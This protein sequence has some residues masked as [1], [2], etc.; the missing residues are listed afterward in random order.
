[1][2]VNPHAAESWDFETG[3]LPDSSPGENVAPIC[4]KNENRFF[5]RGSC[6]G[7]TAGGADDKIH[8]RPSNRAAVTTIY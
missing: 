4:C 8:G 3:K 5:A 1:M 6:N 7:Q 2:C